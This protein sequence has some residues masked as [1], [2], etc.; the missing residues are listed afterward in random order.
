MPTEMPL[1]TDLNLNSQ[2]K[3]PDE[4]NHPLAELH[5]HKSSFDR[6]SAYQSIRD[7][8]SVDD[9]QR[10]LAATR[11]FGVDKNDVILMI[12]NRIA[13]LSI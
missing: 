6:R 7:C 5:L 3:Q 8:N 11:A 13:E 1:V 9:L 10:A 2:R 12:E 4:H